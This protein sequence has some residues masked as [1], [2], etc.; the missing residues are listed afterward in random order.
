MK[1][2]LQD[3]LRKARQG[4]SYKR[5]KIVLA[6][7]EEMIT[8]MHQQGINKSALAERLGTSKPY[9]TKI[10]SGSAN[11]TLDSM[12][13]IA[14]A[15]GSEL[16]IHLTGKDCDTLWIDARKETA[17]KTIKKNSCP[18]WEGWRSDEMLEKP[19]LLPTK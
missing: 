2:K 8:L 18:T 16:S 1:N 19:Q 4:Q 10:M 5:E 15:L 9:I 6:L 12:I 14:D 3:I 13:Q 7:T 11:F 17:S